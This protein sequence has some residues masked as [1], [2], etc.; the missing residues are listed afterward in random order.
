MTS[1]ANTYR[2][3]IY[4]ES[5]FYLM[6]HSDNPKKQLLKVEKNVEMGKQIMMNNRRVSMCRKKF[7][8]KDNII[9]NRKCRSVDEILEYSPLESHN[10]VRALETSIGRFVNFTFEQ[11]FLREAK[12]WKFDN[13]GF[14]FLKRKKEKRKE[15]RF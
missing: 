8:V 12:R 1:R 9:Q 7:V 4:T 5:S 6:K 2:S 10:V 3:V 15:K 14:V 11:N 13:P